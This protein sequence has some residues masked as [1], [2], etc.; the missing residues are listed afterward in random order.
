MKMKQRIPEFMS[1]KEYVPLKVEELFAAMEIE[2][3][4]GEAF[5]AALRELEAEG[6]VLVSKKKRYGLCAHMNLLSGRIEGKN[7]GYAFFVPDMPNRGDLFIHSDDLHGALHND[8]VLVRVVKE[9]NFVNGKD[10]GEVT[11]IL[12]RA[13]RRI[14]GTF[15]AGE[16]GGT[17]TPEDKHLSCL[18]SVPKSLNGGA[19]H[20]DVVVAEVTSW[21]GN[22]HR[23]RG[24]VTEIVGRKNQPGTDM[25]TVIRKY[26][27]PEEFP[28][29][30]LASARDR[31]KIEEKDLENRRD[32]REERI[33]TIDGADARDLDDAVSL[34]RT[35]DGNFLLGVH[36]ADVGH[37]VPV[38]SPLDKEAYRRGTSV[39]FPDRVIPML[40]KELSNGICSLNPGEDRLTLSCEMEID[41]KG[42][43][44]VFDIFE[45]VIRST[46]RMTYDDVNAILEGDGALKERYSFL[47]DLLFELDDLREVLKKRREKRG[48]LTFDFPEAKVILD[49]KGEPLEIRKRVMGRGENIIEECMIAANETVASACYHR[50]IPLIYRVHDCPNDEKLLDLADL[51][52]PFGLTLSH[53]MD[54]VRPYHFQKLLAKIEDRPERSLLELLVLRTMSHALYDAENRGHFGLASDCYCHFTSPIRRYPDLCVHRVVK[55]VLRFDDLGEERSGRL[56]RRLEDAALQSSLR[57]RTAEEAEREATD[58][59]KALY[60]ASHVE[61]EFDGVISGVTSYGFYVELENTVDGLVHVSSLEGDFYEYHPNTKTLVGKNSRVCFRLG[62][63]VR[64]R[65]ARVNVEEHLIDFEFI[66]FTEE[67]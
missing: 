28:P 52:A 55:D 65:V 47:G 44:V 15:S 30:V 4:E 64:I 46:A 3:K 63:G 53:R 36:I 43:V 6:T 37:Y 50:D 10:E 48:A 19:E 9:Q 7:G 1:R 35:V 23:L 59:K 12:T 57:E 58:I 5:F 33:I 21:G 67:E 27:L 38:G 39:Y 13:N 41:A 40:P 42:R 66:D 56:L 51:L 18:V 25:E 17:V 54:D 11:R 31:A 20:G 34:K 26:Q 24:R 14:I 49:E 16:G 60:M 61:E 32:L 29:E 22:S 62:D 8:R 45:S 2:E